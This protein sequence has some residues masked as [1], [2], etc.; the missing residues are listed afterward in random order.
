MCVCESNL[1][2]ICISEGFW[3]VLIWWLRVC[4]YQ[5]RYKL[6]VQVLLDGRKEMQYTVINSNIKGIDGVVNQ[7]NLVK[8]RRSPTMCQRLSCSEE[9]WNSRQIA[10]IFQKVKSKGRHQRNQ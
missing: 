7:A 5:V 4:A 1:R 9:L 8:R 10:L 6:S 3:G 2:D